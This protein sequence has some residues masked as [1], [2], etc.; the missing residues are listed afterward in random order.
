MQWLSPLRRDP[1]SSDHSADP[2]PIRDVACML[3]HHIDMSIVAR[4]IGKGKTDIESLT[5]RSTRR[6]PT[7]IAGRHTIG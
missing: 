5:S 3:R 4:S 2:F 1:T 7:M 6:K